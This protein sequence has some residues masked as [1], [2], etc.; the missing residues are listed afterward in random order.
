MYVECPAKEK[1]SGHQIAEI[2]P[3]WNTSLDAKKIPFFWEYAYMSSK[4]VWT[5][6]VKQSPPV[7]WWMI[8]GF[9]RTAMKVG[10]QIKAQ[11]CS[12]LQNI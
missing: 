4:Y 6:T 12:N 2:Q 1:L 10:Q 11:L 3:I 7:W 9:T 8:C 5:V